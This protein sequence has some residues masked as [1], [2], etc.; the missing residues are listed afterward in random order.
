MNARLNC[1]VHCLDST[2]IYEGAAPNT[3]N[4]MDCFMAMMPVTHLARIVELTNDKLLN[5]NRTLTTTEKIL[6]LFGSLLL[7]MRVKFGNRRDLWWRDSGCEYLPTY[8]FGR[9]MGR[10][11]S[12]LLRSC[13]RFRK[14]NVTAPLGPCINSEER[15]LR[16]LCNDFIDAI[17]A[18]GQ[19]NVFPSERL[20]VDE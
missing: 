5:Q 13:I 17:N 2:F 19:A 20:C 14:R 12:E 4:A 6:R 9:A 10:T 16:Q 15:H 7:M 18:H 1:R 8:N 3:F 11:S